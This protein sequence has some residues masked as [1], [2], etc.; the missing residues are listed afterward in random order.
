MNQNGV[1]MP[2]PK[3]DEAVLDIGQWLGRRQAFGMLASRCTAA[4]AECLKRLRD[5]KSYKRLGMSWEEFCRERA[6]VSRRHADK[7]IKDLEEFGANYYRI[8]ELTQMSADSYRLIAGAVSDEG[9]EYQGEKIALTPDN[10][11]RVIEAIDALK[12]AA[13]SEDDKL[14]DRLSAVLDELKA[15]KPPI[16]NRLVII[17]ML[18]EVSKKLRN[19]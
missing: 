18:E 4:D 7:L 16:P 8:A 2:M 1:T 15:R 5:S 10:R 14:Q 19:L 9:I 13:R 12:P 17:G 11:K 6:G 3:G